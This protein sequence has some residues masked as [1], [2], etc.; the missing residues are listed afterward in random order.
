M[1]STTKTS[2]MTLKMIRRVLRKV[3]KQLLPGGLIIYALLG[4]TVCIF[5]YKLYES[6]R[7]L[8]GAGFYVCIGLCLYVGG[9]WFLR[10][11][12]P[13]LTALGLI[14]FMASL[15]VLSILMYVHIVHPVKGL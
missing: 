5:R 15:V 12:K 3:I 1:K 8:Y 6:L 11:S 7:D 2:P 14:L 13:L 9:S 4:V 10:R